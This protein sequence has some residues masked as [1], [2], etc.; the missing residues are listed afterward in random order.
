VLAV[1]KQSPADKA[2]IRHGDVLLKIG[3]VEL[4]K[5]ELLSQAA[6]RYAGQTVELSYLRVKQ[7]RKTLITLN[8][9]Q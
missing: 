1:V 3:D 2:S 8:K 9:P 4:N 6:R 5:P 7:P